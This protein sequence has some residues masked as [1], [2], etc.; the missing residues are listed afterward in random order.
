MRYRAVRRAERYLGLAVLACVASAASAQETQ[1][2]VTVSTGASVET[3]PYNTLNSGG[4][5]IAATASI[6]PSM[7]WRGEF[8]TIE[9][10]GLASFRQFTKRY[11][12]EDNYSL[13]GSISTRVAERLTLRSNASFSYN[14]GGFNDFGRPG[15]LPGGLPAN[16]SD[17]NPNPLPNPAVIDPTVLGQRV[18]TTAFDLG[19]GGT[20]QLNAYSSLSLDVSG[21][22]NRFRQIGFGDF[23]TVTGRASYQYQLSELTSIGLI[24]SVSRTDYLGTTVGDALTTSIM[25]SLDRRL[26]ANW[27]L[28][29][30]A[31]LAITRIDQL[32]GL[33]DEKFNSLTAAL[34]FCNQ[35][36]RGRFC[37]NGS[38]APE[39]SAFGNVRV[40][41]SLAADYSYRVTERESV[42]VSGSYA[43]TGSGRGLVSA[44]P[45]V[46]FVSGA[47]RYD[48]Q[49]RN[50]L[51]IYAATNF[52]K[53]Y[54]SDFPRKANFGVN[55]GVQYRFGAM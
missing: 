13:D 37:V 10:G 20:A 14:Q 29:G 34:S 44:L 32:P 30:S 48:N 53:F 23:N 8:S 47:I 22:G 55:A 27:T 52:S 7:R 46:D 39:P 12:L 11:G 41:N 24:G 1:T 6:R 51:S 18:R 33:P 28:T 26:N 42:T 4:A 50:N 38:R 31:G 2:S 43:H 49:F 45:A 25:G 15:L 17:P 40:N 21:R 16:P 9:L 5:S 35:G 36:E 19:V 54:S 3:N